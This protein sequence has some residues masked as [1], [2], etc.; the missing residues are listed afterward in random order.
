MQVSPLDTKHYAE[1]FKHHVP[2][3]IGEDPNRVDKALKYAKKKDIKVYNHTFMESAKI[4]Y[5]QEGLKGYMRG[6]TPSMLKNTLNS[7]TYFSML[8]YFEHMYRA[9]P[10]VPNHMAEMLASGSA[11]T[12]QTVICNPLIVIKTRFEVVGFQEYA[13]TWDAARKIMAQEGAAGFFTGLKISLIRDVP[14]SG[15]FYPFYNF[16]KDKYCILFGLNFHDHMSSAD[17][18]M[19]LAYIT[20]LASFSAN[21][22]SCVVTHPLDLI[23]TRVYFQFYNKDKTQ[24]Y[25]SIT[26]AILKIYEHDGFQG[27]FRG[28]LPR[29]ARKGFGSIIAWGIYEYLVDKEDALIF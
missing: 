22:V 28:L 11:K 27:Y 23:R 4:I 26:E 18:A 1:E 10:F 8:Y 20:S 24:H 25:N 9:M 29:I 6:F 13:H 5:R 15:I 19:K 7:G 21:V 17:R 3:E 12:I 14:F 2:K 16:F